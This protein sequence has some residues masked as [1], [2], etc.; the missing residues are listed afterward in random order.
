MIRPAHVLA[1]LLLACLAGTARADRGADGRFEVRRSSHF[2]LRQDVD[3]DHSTGVRG[4]RQFERDVLAVL[5]A[6]YDRLEDDLGLRPRRR[7]DVLVY[8]AAIFDGQ[9]GGL[10]GFRAA[11]FYAGVIRVRGDVAV[12]AALASTLRHELVHA[13][14]DAAAPSLV[15]PAWLNEGLAEWFEARGLGRRGLGPAEVAALRAAAARGALPSLADLSAPSFAGL[16]ND[17]A[18]LAYLTSYALVDHL[19]RLKGDD[20][21]RELVEGLVRS[22]DLERSLQR[23]ARM[24]SLGLEAS[25]HAELGSD[26]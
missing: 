10:F 5:E 25:L 21:V 26:S 16:S 8:D 7:I 22:R 18:G 13:G 3:I 9:F 15:L 24:S 19:A 6:G 23:A 11:G 17:A 4:S 20:A 1:A 14:L 12:S 2:V